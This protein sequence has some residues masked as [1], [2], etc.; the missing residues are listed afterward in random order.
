MDTSPVNPV[1]LGP[2]P[3]PGYAV[4]VGSFASGRNALRYKDELEKAGFPVYVLKV[5]RKG[6]DWYRVQVGAYA[7]V[8]EARTMRDTFKRKYNTDTII[9]RR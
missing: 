4:Q 5:F 2:L 6:R 7:T 3:P 8:A 9:V 1:D